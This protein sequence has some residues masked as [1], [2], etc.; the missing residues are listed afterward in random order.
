MI[1]WKQDRTDSWAEAA[2]P[3][4]QTRSHE[5]LDREVLHMEVPIIRSPLEDHGD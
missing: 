1:S 2:L 4:K 5:D 3:G